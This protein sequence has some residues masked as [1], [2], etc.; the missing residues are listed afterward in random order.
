[1]TSMVQKVIENGKFYHGKVVGKII[2]TVSSARFQDATLEC[3]D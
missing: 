1:M 2:E 3:L